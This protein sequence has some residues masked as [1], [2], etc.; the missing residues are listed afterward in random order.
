M[1]SKIMQVI[2][3]ASGNQIGT[4]NDDGLMGK[5]VYDDTGFMLGHVLSDKMMGTYVQDGLGN[6]IEDDDGNVIRNVYEAARK[7]IEDN[8]AL[9]SIGD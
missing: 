9:P 4:I 2:R 5:N 8:N 1:A 3:D 6:I 7:M